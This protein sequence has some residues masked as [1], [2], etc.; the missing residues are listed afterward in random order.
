ML[1]WDRVPSTLSL[2]PAAFLG[3]GTGG[4]SK[5]VRQRGSGRGFQAK[6]RLCIFL[7]RVSFLWLPG[8]SWCP[9]PSTAQALL[10]PGSA[11]QP[12]PMPVALAGLLQ[13]CLF[14]WLWGQVCSQLQMVM[15]SCV[16]RPDRNERPYVCEFCSHAFT[17]KANLNMHLRTHTGEK[18]FQCHLCGKT[19]RTQGEAGPSPPCSWAEAQLLSPHLIPTASLDK[20]NRTHTGERP[21]SCEFCEQR[22]TEKGP[23]LR[24]VASRHQEGRPHFCQICGKT[25]K[26]TW[27]WKAITPHLSLGKPWGEQWAGPF[28]ADQ[29]W[30]V[31]SGRGQGQQWLSHAPGQRNLLASESLP[32]PPCQRHEGGA[33][34]TEVEGLETPKGGVEQ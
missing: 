32:F 17:Q 22:F 6:T 21:F 9:F 27:L 7:G 2:A 3:G 5:S 19:F 14:P 24:H 15:A 1:I 11:L 20:H 26:G 13:A 8:W 34:L 18:P 28:P 16:L 4:M 33:A 30:T 10:P 23:L 25:F 31:S 29:S 12:G